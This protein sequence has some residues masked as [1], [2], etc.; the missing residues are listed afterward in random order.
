MSLEAQLN[1]LKQTAKSTALIT[2]R[3]DTDEQLRDQITANARAVVGVNNTAQGLAEGRVEGRAKGLVEG[4]VEVAKNMLAAGM[5][6]NVIAQMTGL[7]IAQ[8][9]ALK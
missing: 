5:D 1:Q 2:H 3:D 4:R 9:Q 7:T 6:D 8:L